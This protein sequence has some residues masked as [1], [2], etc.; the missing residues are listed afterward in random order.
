MKNLL[1][2]LFVFM[3][4][5][6]FAQTSNEPQTSWGGVSERKGQNYFY[7]GYNRASYL[8]SYIQFKGEG[9]DFELKEV[10]ATDMP[11]KFDPNVYFNAKYFSV[12]Q[13]NVRFGRFL[14]DQF[15][16]SV[17]WDHMKYR[18][19]PTQT[20]ILNGYIDTT[21]YAG[22]EF[23]GTFN[24]QQ[25]LYTTSF[26]DFHHSN[27]FNFIRAAAEYR[28]PVWT[29]K[30]NKYGLY[31]WCSGNLGIFLPWTDFTFYGERHLNWL[32]VAG[33]GWS[34]SSGLRMEMGKH[35]FAQV[36]AQFG[37]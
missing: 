22:Q 13:F 27:G 34:A 26:M 7:W 3:G 10:S 24:N 6:T 5:T 32:H 14:T 21:K 28:A 17:G 12:P 2:L 29:D 16:V 8:R 33:W 36:G 11:A 4:I 18:L 15:S 1:L 19:T 37:R 9:Y 20:C 25:I 23:T 30:T 31:M 35:F